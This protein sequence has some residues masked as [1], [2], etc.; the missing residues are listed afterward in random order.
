MTIPLV[1]RQFLWAGEIGEFLAFRACFMVTMGQ[2]HP[3]G[4]PRFQGKNGEDKMLVP[5]IVEVGEAVDL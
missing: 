4:M 2:S 3:S 5:R 1:Y